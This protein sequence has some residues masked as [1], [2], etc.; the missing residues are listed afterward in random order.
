[1][2]RR[3]IVVIGASAGGVEALPKLLG[4]LPE[5]FPAAVFVV[6]HVG[7]ESYLPSIIARSSAMPC[8]H[9]V[10]GESIAPGRIYIAPP[11]HH[12]TIDEK[13]VRLTK[14]PRENRHRP[15]VDPLFRSAAQFFGPRVIGM[16]DGGTG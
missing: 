1:M 2:A 5:N 9:A 16:F 10:D 4:R 3:D 15:A 12:L 8:L 14:G 11:D 6:M 13:T 7:G